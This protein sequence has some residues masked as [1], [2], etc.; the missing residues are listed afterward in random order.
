MQ[1]DCIYAH[2]VERLEHLSLV[3]RSVAIQR[4]RTG[5]L[6]HVFLSKA[7]TSADGDLGANDTVAAKEGRSEDVHRTTLSMRH[8]DLAPEELANDTLDASATHDSEGMAAVRS[9]DAVVLGNS[10]LEPDRNSFLRVKTYAD[11]RMP[12]KTSIDVDLCAL[13]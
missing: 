3:G 11:K 4:E 10:V 8:A 5:L 1:K 6:A 7:D 13:T 2:H 9:D 12:T